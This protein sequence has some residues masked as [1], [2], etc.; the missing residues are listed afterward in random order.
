MHDL[1]EKKK[2]GDKDLQIFVGNIL[3]YG[4]LT[5]LGIVFIGLI[6][7]LIHARTEV[8]DFSSFTQNDFNFSV[9]ITGIRHGDSVSII[10]LG[11]LLLILTPVMRVIFAIIGF[12]KEKD[13]LYTIVSVIVLFVIIISTV[14][15]AVS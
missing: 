5:S 6:I 3:R 2:F 7:Y 15:G 12:Y 14:L 9:F 1:N 8:I 13:L 10:K 4:V 11:V